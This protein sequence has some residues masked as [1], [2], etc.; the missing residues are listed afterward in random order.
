MNNI[1][2]LGL[3]AAAVVVAALLGYTYLVAPNVGGPEPSTSPS[4]LADTDAARR[5]A[6]RRSAARHLWSDHR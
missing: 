2:K 4:P 3:A 6:M 5:S 1:A